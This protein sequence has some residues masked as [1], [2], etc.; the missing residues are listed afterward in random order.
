V[1]SLNS[2]FANK[3]K[4]AKLV[5]MH[6]IVLIWVSQRLSNLLLNNLIDDDFGEANTT[7]ELLA[8]VNK[9]YD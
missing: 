8:L 6:G 4:T 1:P 9:I 3:D 7:G 5:F 2:F